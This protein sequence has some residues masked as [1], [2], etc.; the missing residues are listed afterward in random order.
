M[1]WKRL[2]NSSLFLKDPTEN[3]GAAQSKLFQ[4][5]CF[6]MLLQSN[7]HVSLREGLKED[8]EQKKELMAAI[9]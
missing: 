6:C 3:Q 8:T 4:Y 2:T 5:I 7:G 1:G 9:Q